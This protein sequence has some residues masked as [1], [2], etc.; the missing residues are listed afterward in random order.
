MEP[1]A[2]WIDNAVERLTFGAARREPLV[3]GLPRPAFRS[4][5]ACVDASPASE[6][7]LEW[8]KHLAS[9]HG[10]RVTVASVHAPPR[11][12]SAQAGLSPFYAEYLDLWAKAEERLREAARSAADILRDEGIETACV[13][14]VGRAVPEL[15][16]VARAR[17]ADLII[18]A[19]REHHAFGKAFGSVSDALLDR[20][21]ASVLLARGPPT[22]GRILAPTDGSRAASRALA[23]AI[24]Y[25]DHHQAD[26]E[27]QHVLDYPEEA[28]TPSVG[29]LRDVVARMTLHAPPRIAYTLDAG[30][31]ARR[32]VERAREIGA[33]LIVLGS[34]GAGRIR[35][36]I[37]GS[38]SRRVAAN[39]WTNV[40]LVKE[41]RA[42]EAPR[43]RAAATTAPTVPAARVPRAPGA[44]PDGAGP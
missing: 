44:P 4:I 31:P 30:D 22:V 28:Q 35:G 11:H 18:L 43:A 29:F 25:A 16:R 38:V 23:Y 10:A 27:V 15:A 12:D 33:D 2:R 9:L 8:A 32:I 19:P 20:V 1:G 36:W 42:P 40:L 41:A 5:V 21:P 37:L 26:V 14:S 17:Q 6:R 39:A 34:R 13:V 24:R 3:L 7:A